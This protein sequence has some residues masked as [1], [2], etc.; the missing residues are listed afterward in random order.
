MEK[1]PWLRDITDVQKL[2]D[3]KEKESA[4]L[5]YKESAAL[6]NDEKSKTEISKDVSAFANAV[7]A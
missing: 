4:Y 5:D 7:A 1:D 2:V 6:Q 3:S